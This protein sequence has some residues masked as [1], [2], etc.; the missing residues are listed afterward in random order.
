MS[1]CDKRPWLATDWCPPSQARRRR[2]ASALVTAP[3]DDL[4]AELER[5]DFK[6]LCSDA[7]VARL[8]TIDAAAALIDVDPSLAEVVWD[9]V[10]TI[11]LLDAPPGFDISHSEPR[12]DDRI[13]VSVPA[14]DEVAA[15]RVAENIVHEAMHPLIAD[16]GSKLFSPWK[17]EMRDLQGNLHGVYVFVC[18]RAFLQTSGLSPSDTHGWAYV[19]RRLAEIGDELAALDVEQ[20]KAG[21]TEPAQ[22]L[23]RR[24]L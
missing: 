10:R 5:R 4:R 9:R 20:V 23:L 2:P 24:I 21:L 3:A 1:R 12:W 18:I 17:Q 14:D 8:E 11:Y 16:S 6:F 15:L 19:K 7:A 22:E 13:F